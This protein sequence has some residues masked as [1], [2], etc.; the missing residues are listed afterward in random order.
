MVKTQK[1]RVLTG[2][3]LHYQTTLVYDIHMNFQLT[4]N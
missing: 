1:K 2:G 4:Y 3:D